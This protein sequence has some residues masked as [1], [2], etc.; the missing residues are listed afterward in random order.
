[1]VAGG[2]DGRPPIG[3]LRCV[4]QRA[5]LVGEQYQVAAPKPRV[6][7]GVVQQHHRQHAVHL[8]LVGRQ[9]GERPPKP[10]RLGHQFAV[11]AVDAVASL[12]I[13]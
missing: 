10:E 11:D 3:D 1:M 6:A 7:A 2:R 13:R 5:V 8:L 4:P 9:L 12:K